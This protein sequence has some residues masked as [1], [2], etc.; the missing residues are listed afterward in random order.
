MSESLISEL[1]QVVN[2]EIRLFH[3]LLDVLRNEQP[4][5]VNDDL[6]AIKQ[7]SEAKKHYAEEAAKIEFRRQELVVEL[8]SGFNM[9]P[10]QIDLSRLID[11]IDQQHGSQLEAMRETLMDLNKKIR[12]ANDN[13]SFLIRQSMRYTDRCLDILTGHPGDREMYGKFGLNKKPTNSARSM[14]NRTV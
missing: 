9:D 5:I 10:K 6:E 2:E 12:D 11:V 13:N 8:S 3:A 14:V 4:A 1:I 7:A